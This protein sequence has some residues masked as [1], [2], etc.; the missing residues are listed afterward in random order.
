MTVSTNRRT[1]KKSSSKRS[2]TKTKVIFLEKIKLT[3]DNYKTYL[4]PKLNNVSPKTW[5]LTNRKSFYNWLHKN[6]KD[7]DSSSPKESKKEEGFQYNRVQKLVRDFMQESSPYRGLLLYHGL[8]SGKTCS[9]IAITEALKGKKGVYFVSKAA[10]ERN[11]ID[12]GVMTCGADYMTKNHYWV[13][14]KG[15]NEYEQELIQQLGIPDDIVSENNGAYIIDFSVKKSNYNNLGSVHQTKLY[16][17]LVS[18]I[19]NRF[20]FL[21]IDDTR[22]SKK[23]KEGMFNDQVVI[24]DEVHNLTNGMATG[25]SIGDAFYKELMDA[26]NC[27]IIF[28]SGT[29]IINDIF[30]SAKLYNIL[31]GYIPTLSY[32]LVPEF[33]K[34]LKWNLIKQSFINNPNVDQVVVDKIRKII[35]ISKNPYGFVTH[36][37]KKGVVKDEDKSVDFPTF[38]DTITKKM[39]TLDKLAGFT[40]AILTTEMNTCL[41]ND[42]TEFQSKFYNPDINKLKKPDVFR[43]RIVGLTSYYEKLD[44]TKFPSLRVN[45]LVQIPMSD[46]QLAKYQPF[47]IDEIENMKKRMKRRKADEKLGGSYRIYSRMHCTFCFPDEIGT[48]YDKDTYEL[49]EALEEGHD[50]TD[51]LNETRVGKTKKDRMAEKK[52]IENITKQILKNLD[53]NRET[54]LDLNAENGLAKY[55]PKYKKIIEKILDCK[56]CTYVYSQFNSVVGLKTFSMALKATNKF[57]PLRIE[58]EGDE[59]ILKMPDDE[60]NKFKYIF[61]S[62]ETKDKDLREIYRVIFNSEF[63]KLPPSCNKLKKDLVKIYGDDQNLHGKIIK[64]FL[65]T[66]SGAEGVDLKHIRQIH[67]MEPYWQP[68]L[69]QQIIGRGVRYES[70]TRLPPSERNV[71]AF[72]YMATFTDEQL[73][74]SISGVIRQDVAKYNIKSYS[75][76]G[77]PITSDENLYIIAERKL[78][79]INEAQ[80]LIK[81]SSFDC[82]LNFTDNITMDENRNIVCLDY[83]TSARDEGMAYL[84]T[85]GLEDTID[86]VEL[87]QEDS[88][89]LIYQKLEIPK[90][91]GKFYWR[92]QNKQ[93]GAKDYLYPGDK[94]PAKMA[95]KPKPVGEIIV[96]E[97]KKKIVFFKT[98]KSKSTK[99]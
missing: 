81:E 49:Y 50:E 63:D 24:I 43:K 40:K 42:E 73:K 47:R 8:G 61:Y 54:Y 80:K 5:E 48:P 70:H 85:P 95:R 23:V 12:N 58:K 64:T 68:V 28:L 52:R 45:E 6:F 71:D 20:K 1:K 76:L 9:S 17:Q 92:L 27:K 18:T 83:P 75:K 93:P 84:S 32:R 2:R 21:H 88:I 19:R 60:K 62:G 91:S 97:G 82:T 14:I 44:K 87:D 89:A 33:G 34:E 55:S 56:G 36:S 13:H 46:Y 77:K 98:K 31:R 38:K 25:G 90:N 10:L 57:A 4:P 53:N 22:V 96:K 65:T 99:K 72:I 16:N 78:E 67:I 51:V 3:S 15:N 39:K 79:I 11:F 35:K 69:I 26:T 94:N 29:P 37:N 7:Y 86:I 41:P 66:R 30:E 74:G 59:Y